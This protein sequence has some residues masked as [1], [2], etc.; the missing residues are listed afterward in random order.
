MLSSVDFDFCICVARLLP[1]SP[2]RCNV[3]TYLTASANIGII[4]GPL[5]TNVYGLYGAGV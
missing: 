4:P 1:N 2:V 3:I 5:A